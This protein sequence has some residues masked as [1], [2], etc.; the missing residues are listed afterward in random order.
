MDLTAELYGSLEQAGDPA[1][2]G[3]I[4]AALMWVP[5]F[6]A[7]LVRVGAMFVF[8]PLFGSGR[9]P[10]RVKGMFAV[11]L[12]LAVTPTMPQVA[13]PETIF[14]LAAAI[15]GEILFG[16]AMGMVLSLI[17][18]GAQWAGQMAG[19]QLGFDL[20][21]VVDPQFGAA[22]SVVSDL[23]FMLALVIFLALRGHHAVLLAM[24]ESF[25]A[26]PVFTA[27]VGPGGVELVWGLFAGM[28]VLAAK[29]TAPIVVT[30]LMADVA[31]GFVSKTMPQLNVM[32][33]GM[34]L[35]SLLGLLMIATG[36]VFTSE[37]MTDAL[38]D[39][40]SDLRRTYVTP[41]TAPAAGV[42]GAGGSGAGGGGE[43]VGGG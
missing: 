28:T 15:A 13:W 21:A 11:V 1:V 26:L 35:R 37:V 7:V 30:M 12:A 36:L 14:Q 5:T 4:R 38:L 16:L 43:G 41:W 2:A 3:Q 33:A 31:L 42:G 32:S 22:G 20:G 9:V 10:R 25:D 8:S 6:A 18:V 29:L 40:M 23:Y 34:S 24:T 39:G 27:G 19:Q 17:F